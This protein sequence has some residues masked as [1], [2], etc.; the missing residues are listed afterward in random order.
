MWADDVEG[1]DFVLVAAQIDRA[2]AL[3]RIK[4]PRIAAIGDDLEGVGEIV[5]GK[6]VEIGDGEKFGFV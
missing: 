6:G 1:G 2:D 3:R 5:V 4:V